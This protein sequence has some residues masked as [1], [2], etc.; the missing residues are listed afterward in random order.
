MT[1][2]SKKFIQQALDAKDKDNQKN[3]EWI[4]FSYVVALNNKPFRPEIGNYGV[5]FLSEK[6]KEFLQQ[7]HKLGFVEEVPALS[8]KILKEVI[9]D[10]QFSESKRVG[11]SNGIELSLLYNA[12]TGYFFPEIHIRKNVQTRSADNGNALPLSDSYI[13]YVAQRQQRLSGGHI[14]S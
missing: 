6:L 4:S 12:E 5:G 1:D 8:G 13:A 11:L 3:T 2:I 9:E 14:P 7:Q 10:I